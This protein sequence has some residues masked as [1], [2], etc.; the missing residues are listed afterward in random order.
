MAKLTYL[1]LINRVLSRVPESAITEVSTAVGNALSIAELIN[2]A[3][4]VISMETEWYSLYTTRDFSTSADTA[5]YSLASDFG[6]SIDLVNTTSNRI[7]SEVNIQEI[8]AADSNAD[9]TGDPS[10][11]ALVEPNYRLHPIPNG[12]FVMRDRYYKLPD[13]LVSNSDQSDLPIECEICIINY[14]FAGIK[15]ILKEYP[16]SDRAK[17]DF[18]KNLTKAKDVN[19]D[20]LNRLLRF[21]KTPRGLIRN[22]PVLPSPYGV[23]R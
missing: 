9:M 16:N 10:S 23:F 18:A 1:Q 21:Q 11:F 5:E 3:Q 6:R 7:M 2:E 20:K 12:V 22:L 17:L 13:A 15:E 19:K 14:A 8:D 4:G